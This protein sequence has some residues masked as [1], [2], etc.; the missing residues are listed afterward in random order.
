MKDRA[1][2]VFIAAQN[3]HRTVLSL[4]ITAGA[5]PD[6]KRIDGAT[7][8]LDCRTIGT[9]PICKVLCKMVHS[10]M[11]YVAMVRHPLKAAHK[12]HAAVV[13]ELL[14]QT[15]FGFATEWRDRV[16]CGCHVWPFNRL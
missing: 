9:R 4:L 14:T 1:T 13:T 8:T 16:A 7:H 2:P 5:N 6:M 11:R 10:W 12:G 3:G 15:Q